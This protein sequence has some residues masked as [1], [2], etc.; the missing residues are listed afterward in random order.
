MCADIC[1][2]SDKRCPSRTLCYRYTCEKDTYRQAYWIKSPRKAH[3]IS[4][5]EFWAN[6]GDPDPSDYTVSHKKH[7]IPM[8]KYNKIMAGIIK[9]GKPISDTLIELLEEAGK[10]DI[11]QTAL[12]KRD[13]AGIKSQKHILNEFSKARLVKI[14][15]KVCKPRKLRRKQS[16]RNR[17]QLCFKSRIKDGNRKRRRK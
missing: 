13:K 5:N 17:M 8:S 10:Y 15:P 9:K 3:A 14:Q 7:T 6:K 1:A 4:C 2:C 16:T 11:T 12:R